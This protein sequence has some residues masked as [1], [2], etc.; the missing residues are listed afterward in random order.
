MKLGFKIVLFLLI[1]NCISGLVYSIS[2]PGVEYSYA[3]HTTPSGQDYEQNF[4]AT[5]FM[6]KQQPGILSE[7][8]FLGNIYGTI[9]MLWN[10]VTF[11]VTGFPALLEQLGGFIPEAGA[12]KAS[13]TAICWVLRG[14]FS[15]IIFGWLFQLITGR[16]AED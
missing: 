14:V 2:V 3:T 13:Y 12:G 7:I 11:I 10:A 6:E 9:M 8:P 4:N 1:L 16:Q 5:G 15:L